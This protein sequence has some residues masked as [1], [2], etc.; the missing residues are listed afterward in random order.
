[1][2]FRSRQARASSRLEKS[3][4]GLGMSRFALR[5]IVHS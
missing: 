2:L 3:I 4:K 1:V 5:R